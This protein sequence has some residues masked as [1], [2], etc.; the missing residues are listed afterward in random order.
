VTQPNARTDDRTVTVRVPITIRQRGGRKLVL[1]P[2]GR[3]VNEAPV[4]CQ[5][6]TL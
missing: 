4:Y 5:I 3:N 2:D 1:T 6:E